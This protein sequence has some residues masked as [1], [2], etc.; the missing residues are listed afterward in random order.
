M[1]INQI[2]GDTWAVM[3]G[4]AHVG[5][6]RERANGFEAIVKKHFSGAWPATVT[7]PTFDDALRWIESARYTD[8]RVMG[9][10]ERVPSHFTVMK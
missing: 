10:K 1:Q 2:L 6:I 4:S 3:D 9:R 8:G 5:T 7:V